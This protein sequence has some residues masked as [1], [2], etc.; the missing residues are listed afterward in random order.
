MYMKPMLQQIFDELFDFGIRHFYFVVG[1]GKRAIEDHFTPDYGFVRRLSRKSKPYQAAHLKEFY[2]KIQNSTIVWV[3]QPEPKG[4]GDA[5]LQAQPLIGRD[6]FLV[7][8][9]DTYIISRK[10]TVYVKLHEAYEKEQAEAIITLKRVQDAR[11]YGVAEGTRRNDLFRIR[12]V[13]EKPERPASNLAIMP[14]Y[15]F[16]PRIFDALRAMP[17]GKGGEIQLT[18]GIQ[19][20][21][22][23][24]HIVNAIKLQADDTRLDIGTPETYWEALK[25]SFKTAA[26]AEAQGI[27]S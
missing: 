23:D 20:L 12:R 2:K 24:G 25:T 21:I 1:R 27:D 5:V 4:F 3:N 6:R 14:I 9:G 8:A 10:K 18:D 19:R 22:D 26:T 7:H 16:T 15:I 17:A 11:Q 13:V